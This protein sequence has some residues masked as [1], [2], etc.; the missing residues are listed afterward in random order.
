MSSLHY[1][2]LFLWQTSCQGNLFSFVITKYYNSQLTTNCNFKNLSKFK[3]LLKDSTSECK[4]INFTHIIWAADQT[5]F[6]CW[7]LNDARNISAEDIFKRLLS[8]TLTRV[9]SRYESFQG[10]LVLN[11]ISTQ[12]TPNSKFVLDL[13]L[14]F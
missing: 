9:C 3:P 6:N 12:L 7:K 5:L 1:H 8:C 11:M 13:V 14:P 10:H 4:I 2:Q